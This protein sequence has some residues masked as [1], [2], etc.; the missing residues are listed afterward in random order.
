MVLPTKKRS[1]KQARLDRFGTVERKQRP[2]RGAAARARGYLSRS[3]LSRE[4]QHAGHELIRM[5]I[6]LFH[7]MVNDNMTGSTSHRT[8]TRWNNYA[9][10]IEEF[11]AMA[12]GV[13]TDSMLVNGFFTALAD[14]AVDTM[15]IAANDSEKSNPSGIV[16]VQNVI[17]SVKDWFGGIF[18]DPGNDKSDEV[19][20]QLPAPP[21]DELKAFKDAIMNRDNNEEMKNQGVRDIQRSFHAD[22][23]YFNPHSK[24]NIGRIIIPNDHDVNR[25]WVISISDTSLHTHEWENT[26]GYMVLKGI[27]LTL[28]AQS[29]VSLDDDHFALYY[30]LTIVEEGHEPTF[31]STTDTAMVTPECHVLDQNNWVR[32]GQYVYHVYYEITAWN[33][34]PIDYRFH[35]DDVNKAVHKGDRLQI[36][37]RITTGDYAVT[38]YTT[39]RA[40][41]HSIF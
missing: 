9:Q 6:P 2:S 39:L 13:A 25:N 15:S 33:T 7:V 14:L 20:H 32:M 10:L 23:G 12:F 11:A 17:Q 30:Y 18:E 34:T 24:E 5:G 38:I 36:G 29:P 37:Y 3:G 4:L 8:Q 26:S 27:T 40:H 28:S 16:C 19:M 21:A 41:F 1:S 31:S 35:Q 22:Y